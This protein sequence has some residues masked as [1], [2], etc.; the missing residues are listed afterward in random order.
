MKHRRKG[1]ARRNVKPHRC[2]MCMI[3]TPK[4]TNADR[5]WPH[6]DKKRM[7]RAA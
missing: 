6:R 5:R 3:G 2:L 7:E 1:K 4:R